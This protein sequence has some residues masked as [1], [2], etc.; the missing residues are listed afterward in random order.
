[1]VPVDYAQNVISR[2]IHLKRVMLTSLATVSTI[3]KHISDIEV[4]EYF[5]DF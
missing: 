3:I 1:M 2:R 5:D 4:S